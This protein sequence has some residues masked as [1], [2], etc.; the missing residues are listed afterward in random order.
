[1]HNVTILKVIINRHNL[2]FD[3]ESKTKHVSKEIKIN[4]LINL[5]VEVEGFS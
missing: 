5:K 3:C 1:M 4:I 2:Y